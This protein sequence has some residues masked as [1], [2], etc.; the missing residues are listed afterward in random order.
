[1]ATHSSV[2]AWRIPGTGEPGGLPSVGSHRV[3]HDWSDL[4]AAAVS[5]Q[6]FW[7]LEV[8]DSYSYKKLCSF[9]QDS[10]SQKLAFA[11]RTQVWFVII[12]APEVGMVLKGRPPWQF[13]WAYG[14]SGG[15][16]SSWLGVFS[17]GTAP[18]A[19]TTQ[20]S[21]AH[22]APV[23]KQARRSLRPLQTSLVSKG[24][25]VWRHQAVLP[26]CVGFTRGGALIGVFSFG[27]SFW[28][29]LWPVI[30]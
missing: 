24:A 22:S 7:A 3:R 21:L 12:L 29:P 2:L 1:M 26:C 14:G 18:G 5:A 17:S 10:L 15:L 30:G 27:Q 11:E 9:P 4:A 19:A 28:F 20:A 25:R 13:A 6:V 23:V 16:C 8:P